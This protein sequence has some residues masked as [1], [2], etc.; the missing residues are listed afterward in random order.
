[1]K[2]DLK[3]RY[4]YAV[5]RNLPQK[6]RADV[7]RELE[8]LITEM[9]EERRGNG[10]GDDDIEDVLNQLGSPDELALKYSSDEHTALISGRNYLAY[11]RVLM[12]VLPIVVAIVGALSALNAIVWQAEEW[13]MNMTVL[14]IG[15]SNNVF[16]DMVRTAFQT[17]T[18]ITLYFVAKER[19]WSK[20]DG[21]MLESL[22]D[23]PEANA[24]LSRTEA[25][26][27]IIVSVAVAVLFLGYPQLISGYFNGTWV[28]VFDIAALRALWLPILGW[29]VVGIAAEVMQFIEGRYT[30]RLAAVTSVA[31]AVIVFCAAAIFLGDQVLNPEFVRR[32]GEIFA[33][34]DVLWLS[35]VFAQLNMYIFGIILIVAVAESVVYVYRAVKARYA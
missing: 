6:A 12:T 20:G 22:P 26:A 29:V 16:S 1:M 4:I 27:G 5:V 32:I 21:D 30:M 18:V 17:F 2:I 28:T 8:G 35:D 33:E 31:N 10:P 19:W 25:F 7:E 24:K 23:L 13:G 3:E 34:T 15:L 11:K 14:N 9:L